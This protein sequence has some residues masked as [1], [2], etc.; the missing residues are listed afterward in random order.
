[1]S[2][3]LKG[4]SDPDNYR[5]MSV[6]FDTGDE[7]E[8][9][10]EQF[11]KSVGELRKACRIQDVTIIISIAVKTGD[12]EGVVLCQGHYGDTTKAEGMAAYAY[13][14]LSEERQQRMIKLL[15]GKNK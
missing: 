10:A 14:K 5:A 15:A 2:A 12:G 7:A 1:M 3:E 9:A 4:S 6:P 11:F 13:G 8:Q